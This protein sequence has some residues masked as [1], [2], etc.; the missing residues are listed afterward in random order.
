MIDLLI[1]FLSKSHEDEIFLSEKYF[2]V[3]QIDLYFIFLPGD[4]VVVS[5]GGTGMGVS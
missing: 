2:S 1:C 5:V 4:L 3:L